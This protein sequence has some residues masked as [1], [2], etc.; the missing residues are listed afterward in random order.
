MRLADLMG[1][2]RKNCSV[3][4][5][6]VGHCVSCDFD[7][8]RVGNFHLARHVCVCAEFIRVAISVK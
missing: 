8:I 4:L 2:Y 7:R 5:D 6:S 1:S 3:S